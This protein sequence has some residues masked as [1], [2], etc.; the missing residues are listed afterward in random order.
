MSIQLTFANTMYLK[1]SILACQPIIQ[2]FK[3][4]I[5]RGPIPISP[6]QKMDNTKTRCHDLAHS[7]RPAA[8]YC[9]TGSSTSFGIVS[10]LH[11]DGFVVDYLRQKGHGHTSRMTFSTE[12]KTNSLGRCIPDHKIAAEL[13]ICQPMHFPCR[14]YVFHTNSIQNTNINMENTQPNLYDAND[15]CRI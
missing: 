4:W 11:G 8:L 12:G 13:K 7:T 9:T 10:L 15:T 3:L 1:F 6:V 14:S 2:K 5:K